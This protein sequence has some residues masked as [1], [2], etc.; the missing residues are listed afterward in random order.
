M[1]EGLSLVGSSRVCTSEKEWP[2]NRSDVKGGLLREG[3]GGGPGEVREADKWT[4]KQ[5]EP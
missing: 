5:A 2:C 3:K 4:W 1:R